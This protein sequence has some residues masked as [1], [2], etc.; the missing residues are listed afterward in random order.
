VT[1][2]RVLEIIL[3]TALGLAIFVASWNHWQRPQWLRDME[4]QPE[5]WL[6]RAWNE[7]NNGR[8]VGHAPAYP[9][10]YQASDDGL[11]DDDGL[12]GDPF[13][14]LDIRLDDGEL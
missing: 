7:G 11:D 8:R 6:Q 9:W 12:D 4:P 13:D 2:K 14:R 10:E 3:S 5:R 1:K